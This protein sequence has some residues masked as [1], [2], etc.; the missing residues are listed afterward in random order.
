M[1]QRNQRIHRVARR[2]GTKQASRVTAAGKTAI[3]VSAAPPA[4][5]YSAR[6]ERARIE[7]KRDRACQSWPARILAENFQN[8]TLVDQPFLQEVIHGVAVLHAVRAA[9]PFG[10]L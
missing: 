9:P 7:Q 6:L 1:P 4:V 2:A 5:G 3:P 8:S 10:V